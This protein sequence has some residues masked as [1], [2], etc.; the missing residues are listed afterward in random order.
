MGGANVKGP[1]TRHGRRAIALP[2]YTVDTLQ[3]HWSQHLEHRLALGLGR[4]NSE[5][6]VFTLPDGAAWSP[7]YLSRAWRRATVTL[8]LPCVG[9]HGLR[10][11]HASVLI[12]ANVDVL[13]ISRQLG[14]ATPAFTLAVYGHLFAK[15][16]AAPAGDRCR[17]RYQHPVL[18]GSGANY[19]FVTYR[20]S[21][22]RLI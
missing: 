16:D 19:G 21:A 6:L 20:I 17:Y 10:H 18:T 2:G 9:L 4:P 8:G 3:A 14:H 1:K 5:D 11:S 22:K 13:T 15:T 7:D 12:A